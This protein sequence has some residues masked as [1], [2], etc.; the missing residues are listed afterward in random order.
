MRRLV[1]VLRPGGNPEVPRGRIDR[2]VR[3]AEDAPVHVERAAA[4]RRRA[5]ERED[6]VVRRHPADDERAADEAR[7]NGVL[8]GS[9]ERQGAPHRALERMGMSRHVR[10]DERAVV[11]EDDV[12]DGERHARRAAGT[13]ELD[14]H[15][16]PGRRTVVRAVNLPRGAPEPQRPAAQADLQVVRESGVRAGGRAEDHLAGAALADDGLRIRIDR[17]VEG[18]LRA[19]AHEAVDVIPLEPRDIGELHLC[20][21]IVRHAAGTQDVLLG[22]RLRH[23]H[24][25]RA[26]EPHAVELH[27]LRRRERKRRRV[28]EHHVVVR[29]RARRK[30]RAAPVGPVGGIVQRSAVL[31]ARPEAFGG[32]RRHGGQQRRQSNPNPMSHVRLRLAVLSERRATTRSAPRTEV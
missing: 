23:L 10:L 8:P 13:E 29:A 3:E 4:R 11:G 7:E 30:G 20:A 14:P 15:A 6:G 27:G 21:G 16:P 25:R 1:A 2:A 5:R 12:L 24:V 31:R 18:G 17:D 19:L 32:G 28:G 9:G 22:G 26:E